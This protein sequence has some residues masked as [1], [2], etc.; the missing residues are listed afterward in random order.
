M[1]FNNLKLRVYIYQGEIDMRSGFERLSYLIREELKADILEGHMY[2]FL[3][4]NRKRAKVLLFDR[5]GL[6]LLSKRMEGGKL[7]SFRELEN[8]NEITVNDLALILAG[9]KIII[10]VSARNGI[11]TSRGF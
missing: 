4:K 1:L 5:T 7:I 9:A 2:L 6:V 11:K 3:G 8:V 10:P